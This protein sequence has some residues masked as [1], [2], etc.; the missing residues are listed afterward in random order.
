M[1]LP[2]FGMGCND[3]G[4]SYGYILE[5][6]EDIGNVHQVLVI[7]RGEG[8]DILKKLLQEKEMNKMKLPLFATGGGKSNFLNYLCVPYGYILEETKE[9]QDGASRFFILYKDEAIDYVENLLQK[10]EITQVQCNEIMEQIKKSSL[11]NNQKALL[12]HIYMKALNETTLSEQ[13]TF[14]FHKCSKHIHLEIKGI[15]N[16]SPPI[17]SVKMLLSMFIKLNDIITPQNML[18]I[19][20]QVLDSKCLPLNEEE[21]YI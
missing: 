6:T 4:F 5:E 9:I 17:E 2:V 16:V 20:K 14:S 18:Y 13:Y 11:M 8:D 3:R 10:E 7:Y 15:D 19:F 12:N 21:N 1:K